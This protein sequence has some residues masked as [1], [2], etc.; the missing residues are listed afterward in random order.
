M[1]ER[2]GVTRMKEVGKYTAFRG[3]SEEGSEVSKM[4]MDI[5]R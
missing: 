3:I 2:C 1:V 4:M 5:W